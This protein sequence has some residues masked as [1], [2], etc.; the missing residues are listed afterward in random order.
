MGGLRFRSGGRDGAS[1]ALV[2]AIVARVGDSGVKAA[3]A[4]IGATTGAA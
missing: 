2:Q 4:E 3:P 1:G